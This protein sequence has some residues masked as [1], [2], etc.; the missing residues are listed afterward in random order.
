MSPFDQFTNTKSGRRKAA[1]FL[2]QWDEAQRC[3]RICLGLKTFEGELEFRETQ[4]RIARHSNCLTRFPPSLNSK[5]LPTLNFPCPC[6]RVIWKVSATDF[7][8]EGIRK[9]LDSGERVMIDVP[10]L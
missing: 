2:V 1:R 9:R 4:S 6:G 7:Q 3:A 10:W 5:K 8:W